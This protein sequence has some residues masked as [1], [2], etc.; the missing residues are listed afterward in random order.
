MALTPHTAGD[1][2][3][4]LKTLSKSATDGERHMPYCQESDQPK[5]QDSHRYEPNDEFFQVLEQLEKE[6][7]AQ[8]AYD[9]RQLEAVFQQA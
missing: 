8:N 1:I 3:M 4:T 7:A 6:A 2:S 9:R 5:E